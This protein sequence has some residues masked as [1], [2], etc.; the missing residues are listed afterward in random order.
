MRPPPP[1]RDD[2]LRF[3]LAFVVVYAAVL[4]VVRPDP[5]PGQVA[6]RVGTMLVGVAG[7][8]VMGWRKRRR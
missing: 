8:G 6:F 3:I 7:L 2:K 5:T 4:F 1:T